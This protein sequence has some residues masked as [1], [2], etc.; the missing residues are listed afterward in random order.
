M[1]KVWYSDTTNGE[2]VIKIDIKQKSPFLEI[3]S[4]LFLMPL[5]IVLNPKRKSVTE[6]ERTWLR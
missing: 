2:E 6:S 1:R 5:K 3:L 4:K